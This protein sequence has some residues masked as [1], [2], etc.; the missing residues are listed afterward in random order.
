[1][2]RS[3]AGIRFRTRKLST[4][5]TLAV[6]REH[7]IDSVDDDGQR[8]IP[9]IETGVERQEEIVRCPDPLF[10]PPPIFSLRIRQQRRKKHSKNILEREKELYTRIADRE[11][12]NSIERFESYAVHLFA[13]HFLHFLLLLLHAVTAHLPHRCS[14]LAS[15]ILVRYSLADFCRNTISKK[16]YRHIRLLQ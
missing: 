5:Q 11:I 10:H 15:S 7:Q 14:P 13:S 3:A 6:L 16:Q 2:T 9:Q 4:K 12:V 8:N 1:M